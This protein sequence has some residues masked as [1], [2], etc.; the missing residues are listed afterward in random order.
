MISGSPTRPRAARRRARALRRLGS[1]HGARHVAT[2]G[3]GETLHVVAVMQSCGNHHG[4]DLS[5]TN[6]LKALRAGC[7]R[8]R[9]HA[10]GERAR[11]RQGGTPGEQG[12]GVAVSAGGAGRRAR[13]SVRQQGH[14][15]RLTK[16]IPAR[17]ARPSELGGRP[18]RPPD[19]QRQ[20]LAASSPQDL[21]CLSLTTATRPS[22]PG[23]AGH[24]AARRPD[25][26]R[27]AARRQRPSRPPR[28]PPSP[29]PRAARLPWPSA[30]RATRYPRQR[31]RAARPRTATRR[32]R[33]GCA[34]V[35]YAR[36]DCERRR[37]QLGR[38]NTPWS[39]RTRAQQRPEVWLAALR[40][41]ARLGRATRDALLADPTKT[42]GSSR[43]PRGAAPR[44]RRVA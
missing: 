20:Q 43:A 14:S 1:L 29:P 33:R 15:R 4:G 30:P 19:P 25:R 11:Y 22:R 12:L 2:L 8:R 9:A 42:A 24:A 39:R 10:G 28:P 13:R 17:N 16:A 31:A 40:A 23:R 38:V 6:P 3:Q 5:L 34:A 37:R 27:G 26:R 44:P 7:S 35:A 36:H 32:A 21:G 41:R 18:Q